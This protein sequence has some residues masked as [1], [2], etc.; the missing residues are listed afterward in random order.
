[1]VF[2]LWAPSVHA[3]AADKKL[4]DYFGFQPLEL[5]KLDHRIG[6]LHLRIWTAIKSM[7]FS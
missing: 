7:T 1:M 6:N 4:S 5:Y 3:Q 2:V